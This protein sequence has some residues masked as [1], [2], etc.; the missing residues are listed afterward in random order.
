MALDA[1]PLALHDIIHTLSPSP[2]P[3][4]PAASPEPLIDVDITRMRRRVEEMGLTQKD[5]ANASSRE[6]ELA[7][8]VRFAMGWCRCGGIL[9]W[10]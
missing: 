8:M 1:P 3:E 10:R 2:T 9:V 4:A 6:Q 5:P 7:D